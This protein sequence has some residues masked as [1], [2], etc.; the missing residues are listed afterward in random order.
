MM[1]TSCGRVRKTSTKIVMAMS[2]ARTR[3]ARTI[4]SAR[5]VPT[6]ARMV[7]SATST[8]SQKPASTDGPYWARIWR[9]K[10]L[11]RSGLTSRG[12][13]RP[14]LACQLMRR[15]VVAL[16]ARRAIAREDRADRRAGIDLGAVP[17]LV[18][19]HEH[20]VLLHALDRVLD[21]VAVLHVLEPEGIAE[22]AAVVVLEADL[23]R[24]VL[25]GGEHRGRDLVERGEGAARDHRLNRVGEGV[26]ALHLEAVLLGVGGGPGVGDRA[27]VDGEL[28]ALQVLEAR[29]GVGGADQEAVAGGEERLGIEHLLGALGGD[30]ERI[31]RA[32][33]ALGEQRREQAGEVDVDDLDARPA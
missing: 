4:A 17:L 33:D 32:L 20:A 23:D 29:H 31:D 8:V 28:L 24:L 2:A 5:P 7:S 21:G 6:P 14:S 3:I 19:L 30:V 11:S 15:R 22:I 9:L 18:E 1:M 12:R 25:A 26:V 13:P 27:A 16:E 10:K